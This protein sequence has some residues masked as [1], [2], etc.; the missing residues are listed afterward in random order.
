MPDPQVTRGDLLAVIERA[1]QERSEAPALIFEDGLTV[2]RGELWVS[3]MSFAGFL[4]TRVSQGDR[5]AIMLDNRPEFMV[6]WLATIACRAVLLPLN[7]T[8]RTIDAGHILRDSDA[9]VV[10]VSSEH[11]GL[12]E[13]LRP[14]CP[15]IS[16]VIVVDGDEPDGL[17]SYSAPFELARPADAALDVTNVYYTSG[18]TGPPK[19]CLVDHEYWLR[20]V[21]I[22]VDMYG[23]SAKDRM[24]CCLQF[25]YND[26]PWQLLLSLACDTALV[27]MRRFSVSRY[28]D[29]VRRNDVTVLFG[30]AATASLLLKAETDGEERNHHVRLAIQVGIPAELHRD[31]VERWGAPWVEGYGLT[32]TGLIACMPLEYSDKM[33][34]SGSIG[35]QCPGTE[36]RVV[37]ADD[38]DVAVGETGEIVVRGPGLMR[39]YLNRP[40]ATAETM[41]NGWL[42]TGDLGRQDENGFLYFKGRSKDIIR[43]SGE[44]IAAAE[45]EGVVRSHPNVLEAAA[46]PVPDPLRGEEVKIHVQLTPGTSRAEV[47]PEAIVAFCAERLAAYKVPRY[48][49]FR[50]VAFERTPSMRVKK[51]QLDRS[52]DDP[53]RT[54]DR[55]G[56][57]RR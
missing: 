7:P 11:V 41:R 26:P 6:T 20:F 54:F 22:I 27:V 1:C 38:R 47:T 40:E 30:I 37:D 34:G 15:A 28:W 23:F 13:E 33:V 4:S 18:T 51:E 10:I 50:E 3:A 44:N 45:V 17:S 9:R 32:E 55:E 31:L 25:F 43:R 5:V 57:S 16:D 35:R 21:E 14:D 29:V 46:V 49:E 42:H 8:L 39:G 36:I 48:V 2:S 53:A 24:L 12:I 56:G 52:T 19:G